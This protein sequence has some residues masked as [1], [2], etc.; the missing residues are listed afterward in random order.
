[1]PIAPA[2]PPRNACRSCGAP[3]PYSGIGRP[4]RTCSERCRLDLRAAH[5]RARR[6]ARRPPRQAPHATSERCAE[7]TS[8][9]QVTREQLRQADAARAN[10]Y[11]DRR[12]RLATPAD[13]FPSELEQSTAPLS[14]GSLGISRVRPRQN[15]RGT[16]W[17]SDPPIHRT[18]ARDAK[19]FRQAYRAE[20][21]RL[22]RRMALTHLLT[23]GEESE[24]LDELLALAD[25]HSAA[26]IRGLSAT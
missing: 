15:G 13:F 25:M 26:L 2:P 24:V 17:E 14:L 16:A 8:L 10:R 22:A 5:A 7:V 4:P 19:A 21:R 20:A 12:T 6:G 18:A 9:A 11:E 23:T 1:M 3:V